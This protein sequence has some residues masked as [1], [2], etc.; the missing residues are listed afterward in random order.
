VGGSVHVSVMCHKG[1]ALENL[2]SPAKRGLARACDAMSLMV[3]SLT[4][5]FFTT[6]FACSM[7]CAM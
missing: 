7:H 3:A 5:A 6:L 2:H 1:V 4:V